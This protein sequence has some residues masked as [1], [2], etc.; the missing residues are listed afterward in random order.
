MTPDELLSPDNGQDPAFLDVDPRDG[1][2]V[3][4]F[5]IQA[6]KAAMMSDIVVYGDDDT[7]QNELRNVA[8]KI[9]SA[10]MAWRKKHSSGGQEIPPFE[11]FVVV[12]SE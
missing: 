7:P 4:N 3:R 1:F 2:S 9:A 8:K 10:Q 6:A 11:T 12:S 5:H